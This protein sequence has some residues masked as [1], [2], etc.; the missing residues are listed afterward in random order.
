M[1]SLIV[2][3]VLYFAAADT[4]IAVMFILGIILSGVLLMVDLLF[5]DD[6]AFAYEPYYETWKAKTDPE[7]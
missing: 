3:V 5:L 4:Q 7:Y 1:I 6:K 2:F